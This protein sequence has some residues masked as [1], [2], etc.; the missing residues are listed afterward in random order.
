[1]VDLIFNDPREYKNAPLW[2][3][4][5]KYSWGGNTL[6]VDLIFNDWKKYKNEKYDED[7]YLNY[8]GVVSKWY[9]LSMFKILKITYILFVLL[10]VVMSQTG[11]VQAAENVSTTTA[12]TSTSTLKTVEER[13]REYFS[14]VP[15][16]IDI[17]RCESNFRQFND[18]GSV[19][20]GGGGDFIGI[21]QISERTHS[22]SAKVLGFDLETVEGNMGYSKY[23]YKQSGASPWSSCVP[24]MLSNTTTS[25]TS[26]AAKL[27]QIK[28][29]NQI[30][31]LLKQVIA[32]QAQLRVK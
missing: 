32:L 30:I 28:L 1:M 16:M 3:S 12:E 29:L 19:L 9:N 25:Y 10:L 22:D 31:I 21:F 8:I 20:R 13:V 15:V 18:S 5:W 4:Y 17:A 23:L 6:V 2:R 7:N 24:K 27:E 14:D 26:D 11:K